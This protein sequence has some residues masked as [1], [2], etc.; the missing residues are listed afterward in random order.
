MPIAPSST[1]A[2]RRPIFFASIALVLTLTLSACSV[3]GSDDATP[4]P[5][6]TATEIPIPTLE[7]GQESVGD[8]LDRIDAATLAVVSVRKVE[9]SSQ[10]GDSLGTPA[11]TDVVYTEE[12]IA[13]ASRR[14]VTTQGATT[15]DEQLWVNGT[16]YFK[17]S[18]V[19]SYIA[20]YLGTG[21]WVQ[22]DPA[23]VPETSTAGQNVAYL[24]APIGAVYGTVSDDMRRRGITEGGTIEVSG[25]TCTVYTFVDTTSSGQKIDYALS[26]DEKNLPCSLVQSASGYANTTLF[27]FDDPSIAITPPA[28]AIVVSATPEG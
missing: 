10:T 7:P 26:V 1:N 25:R 16:T 19:A 18:S 24:T 8:L 4:T 22:V 5:E 23:G 21:S 17:G 11:P 27:T 9:W 2:R 28:D 12:T 20:P 15:T 13:P 6:P 3:T 14:V